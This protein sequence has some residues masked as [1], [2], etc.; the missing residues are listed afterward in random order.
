MA[1]GSGLIPRPSFLPYVASE[2]PRTGLIESSLSENMSRHVE[3]TVSY[4][5][6]ADP[7]ELQDIAEPLDTVE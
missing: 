4:V 6:L 2:F 3:A 7:G 5:A 1:R